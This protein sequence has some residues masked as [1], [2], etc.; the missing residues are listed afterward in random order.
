QWREEELWQ[1]VPPQTEK[2]LVF[3]SHLLALCKGLTADPIRVPTGQKRLVKRIEPRISYLTHESEKITHPRKTI[4][5]PQRTYADMHNE[6]AS[7]LANLPAFTARAKI[8]TEG[9]PT[10]F[11][12]RTLEPERGLGRIALQERIERI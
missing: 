9:K 10:E 7:Q 1:K 6:V 4:M 2:L 8:A 3:S 11:T 12:I 5:H